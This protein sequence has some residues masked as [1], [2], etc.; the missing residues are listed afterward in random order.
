MR[1][2][3]NFRSIP[4]LSHHFG[5]DYIPILGQILFKKQ[6]EQRGFRAWQTILD[7]GYPPALIGASK[8][9]LDAGCPSTMFRAGWML[10][11]RRGFNY[12]RTPIFGQSLFKI[13]SKHWGFRAWQTSRPWRIIFRW[14]EYTC[15]LGTIF[16]RIP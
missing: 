16:P 14:K 15:F 4:A 13:Q 9:R 6:A 5:M 11:A 7:T 3:S 10:V 2:N 8:G 1:K 12:I